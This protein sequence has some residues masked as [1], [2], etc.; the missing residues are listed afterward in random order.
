MFDDDPVV[1][2]INSPEP[3]KLCSQQM[4]AS[5][6]PINPEVKTLKRMGMKN[7]KTDMNLRGLHDF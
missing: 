2:N 6:P 5:K 1:Y 4:I 7:S 3:Q